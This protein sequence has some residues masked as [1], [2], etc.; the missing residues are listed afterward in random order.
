M[1]VTIHQP[2]Q[3]ALAG[4]SQVDVSG[5]DLKPKVIFVITFVDISYGA[6]VPINFYRDVLPEG[7]LLG[8]EEE[9]GVHREGFG[10][11]HYA[12]GHPE[13]RGK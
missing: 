13:G 7:L 8:V 5:M 6:G 2:R 12:K 9:G 10:R 1:G 11:W 3:N 4:A